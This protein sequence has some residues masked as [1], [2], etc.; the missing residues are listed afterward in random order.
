M[1]TIITQIKNHAEA[2]KSA[3]DRINHLDAIIGACGLLEQEIERNDA[4]LDTVKKLIKANRDFYQAKAKEI[5]LERIPVEKLIAAYYER[6][7]LLYTAG[8][9]N[10]LLNRSK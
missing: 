3:P 5:E 9:L 10:E 8:V 2:A 4:P 6:D 1:K 7:R